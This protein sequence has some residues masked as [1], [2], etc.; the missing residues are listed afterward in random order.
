VLS[1]SDAAKLIVARAKLMGELPKGGA[2][3]AIEATEQEVQEAIEGKEAELSIAA[4][5]GP[6][7]IVISGVQQAALEIQARFEEQG[8][9][10]KRLS[11][12]HAF[13]SPLMEPMLAD[14]AKIAE[15]LDYQAPRI[16][17]VSNLSGELL[18]EE[19]AQ[20]P[21]YW[22]SHVRGAVRF[23]QGIETLHAQGVTTF[24]ELGP[25]A[26]LTAMASSCLPEDSTA[27]LIPTLRK[28]R[29]ETESLI[30][31]LASAHTA[32][33]KLEWARLYP[34]AKA[35]PLPT[36]PFQRERYWLSAMSGPTDASSIGQGALDHP[37]LAARV[38]DP[39]GE[40]LTLT[41]RVSL[42]T[43]PWLADHAV[44]GTVILPGTAFV[45]AQGGECPCLLGA[46]ENIL[47]RLL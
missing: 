37:L 16:P 31:A 47:D 28:G 41:G 14:F 38:E 1:L 19:Q 10:T 44:L 35:V 7:A 33:A 12:S 40:R 25:D 15:G 8:K 21:A 32:G 24:I 39:A 36:Y 34:A 22:V 3:V 46:G 29:G 43:H 2:M 26:V 6:T 18:T 11:V 42:S 23:A 27:A 4:V 20:D 5:N 30:G 13:H 45:F 9:R 17:I